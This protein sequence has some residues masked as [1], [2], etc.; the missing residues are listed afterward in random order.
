MNVTL[1]G[2]PRVDEMSNTKLRRLGKIPCHI[3]EKNGQG[4]HVYLDKKELSKCL[5]NGSRKIK[6]NVDGKIYET[7]VSEIQKHPLSNEFIHISFKAFSNNEKIT[8]TIPIL[9]VGTSAG[10][11]LGGILNQR[12]DSITVNGFVEEIPEFLS[13]DISN[14]EVGKSIC[15]SDLKL[16]S[17]LKV[18]NDG[19]EL[20]INCHYPKL[21]LV[22]IE[23][24]IQD[25]DI[26]IK[27]AA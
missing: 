1:T 23:E 18:I 6:I 21:R 9:I 27:K 24:E 26:N 4:R 5:K 8:T 25:L 11:S 19:S 12:L 20:I 14:L 2:T 10:Q 22:D 13:L 15:I 3:S 17:R 16:N 7:V